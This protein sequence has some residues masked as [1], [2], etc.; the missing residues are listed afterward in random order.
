MSNRLHD[1]CPYGYFEPDENYTLDMCH[2]H[3]EK[4]WGVTKTDCQE[5]ANQ[6]PV[7]RRAVPVGM[8]NAEF[9]RSM[10]DEELAKSLAVINNTTIVFTAGQWLEWLRGP[11]QEDK[12]GVGA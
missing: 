8:T 4:I 12:Y 5:C 7:E 10:T 3:P 2:I 11:V 6:P 1:N 9:L